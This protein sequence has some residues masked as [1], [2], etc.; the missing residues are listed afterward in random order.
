MQIREVANITVLAEGGLE[1]VVAHPSHK[2]YHSLFYYYFYIMGIK[3]NHKA[4]LG[5]ETHIRDR[6]PCTIAC[7]A[8]WAVGIN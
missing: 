3:E 4:Q 7:P 5:A 2:K 8:R 6:R 1:G